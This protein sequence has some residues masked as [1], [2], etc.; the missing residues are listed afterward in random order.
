MPGL[1]LPL[2]KLS[3]I[4]VAMATLPFKLPGIIVGLAIVLVAAAAITLATGN[5]DLANLIVTCAYGF[6]AAGVVIYIVQYIRES[7]KC[8]EDNNSTNH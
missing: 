2:T 8:P 3:T 4:L 1:K 7:R 5:S 6:F